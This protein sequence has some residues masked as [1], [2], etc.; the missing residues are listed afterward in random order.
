MISEKAE[1]QPTSGAADDKVTTEPTGDQVTSDPDQVTSEPD[2]DQRKA[3]AMKL[4][5]GFK[6]ISARKEVE[7]R[8]V[9]TKLTS[10]I[11]FTLS[12]PAT[13]LLSATLLYFSSLANL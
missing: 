9:E 4:Q 1:D 3:A 12:L 2:D 5:A 13:Y 11:Q 8:K 10:N 7:R 6:G